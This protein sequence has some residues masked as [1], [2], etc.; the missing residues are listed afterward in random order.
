MSQ[1]KNW[2][3]ISIIV[4]FGLII[5]ACSSGQSSADG[6]STDGGSVTSDS[7]NAN[8]G[9]D[10]TIVLRASSGLPMHNAWMQSVFTPWIER[11]EAESNGRLKIELFPAGELVPLGGEYD[12]LNAGTIDL[13]LP[14]LHIY[15]PHLFPLAE[16]TML[17]L[18]TSNGEIVTEAYYNL[19]F[20]N[21]KFSDGKT[22]YEREFE[23][24]GLKVWAMNVAD[25]Y[26]I[27]TTGQE[28]N[29]VDDFKDVRLRTGMRLN[30]LFVN[31]V[32][33]STI[34]MHMPEAYDALSRG[35]FEGI[36]MSVADWTGWGFQDL[37]NYAL[38]GVHLGHVTA[39][40]GMKQDKWDSLPED[41]QQIME[42]A[43]HEIQQSKE[44]KEILLSLYDEVLE[45]A[46]EKNAKFDH[47]DNLDPEVQEY[48]ES[49][50]EQT[51]YDWIEILEGDGQPGRETA[52]L[53]R[54][55]ILEAGGDVPDS[56]KELE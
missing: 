56:I 36:I 16:V 25:P 43:A 52:I 4:F 40:F 22:Y 27:S 37:F 34:S 39:V 54:D 46:G 35:A 31:N 6:E 44:A 45:I 38:E 55:L 51:W 18:S 23:Q 30:E 41:I 2:L 50:M 12:A 42:T 29:S 15:L 28:F 5:V 47:L 1:I 17:P 33:G 14:I 11:V 49:A 48:V 7:S 24:N 3:F 8:Q 10:E 19:I 9:S 32:G 13:G 21:H 26:V 20:G 53:W